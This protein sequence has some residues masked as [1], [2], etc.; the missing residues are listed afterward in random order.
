L[1]FSSGQHLV[2]TI[3][4]WTFFPKQLYIRSLDI[5]PFTYFSLPWPKV[6]WQNIASWNNLLNQAPMNKAFFKNKAGFNLIL[7]D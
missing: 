3:F 2:G 1:T 7:A 4:N 5:L 6:I